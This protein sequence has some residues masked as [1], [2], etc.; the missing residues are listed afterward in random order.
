MAIPMTAIIPLARARG[1]AA[2]GANRRI[3]NPTVTGMYTVRRS[4]AI[5]FLVW[6]V[7]SPGCTTLRKRVQYGISSGSMVAVRSSATNAVSIAPLTFQSWRGAAAFPD[8]SP[9]KG[10]S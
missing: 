10:A 1:I 5:T 7:T 4:T 8:R 3:V 2:R 9:T 6:T